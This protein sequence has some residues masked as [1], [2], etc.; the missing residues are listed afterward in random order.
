MVGEDS[1]ITP[2][3]DF[4]RCVQN[5]S[6][7]PISGSAGLAALRVALAALE[8]LRAGGAIDPQTVN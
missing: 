1:F 3:P 7:P 8:L 6:L 4:I 2:A 5:G